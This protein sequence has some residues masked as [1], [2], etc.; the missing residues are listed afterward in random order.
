MPQSEEVALAKFYAEPFAVLVIQ[1][2][3]RLAGATGATPSVTSAHVSAAMDGS[4][5]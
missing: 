1:S 5:M 4:E 2:G 3:A